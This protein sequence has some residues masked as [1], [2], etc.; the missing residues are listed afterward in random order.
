ME[1]SSRHPNLSNA[2]LVAGTLFVG[3]FELP[4]RSLPNYINAIVLCAAELQPPERAYPDIK[5]LHCPLADDLDPL[6]EDECVMVQKTV[7]RIRV[8]SDEG[9]VVLVTCV[10]GLNRSSFIAAAALMMPQNVDGRMFTVGTT[11][12]GMSSAQVISLIRQARGPNALGNP[13]FTYLLAAS[14]L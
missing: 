13:K 3:A 6:T 10:M 2:N 5:V 14:E 9:Q 1:L 7:R 12:G 8:M 11:P 4:R